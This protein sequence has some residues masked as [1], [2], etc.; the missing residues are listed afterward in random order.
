MRRRLTR[1]LQTSLVAPSGYGAQIFAVMNGPTR[2][3]LNAGLHSFTSVHSSLQ[4]MSLIQ[5]ELPQSS[6]VV[7]GLPIRPLP[8]APARHA[9]SPSL[10]SQRSPCA[11]SRLSSQKVPGPAS[12]YRCTYGASDAAS[13]PPPLSRGSAPASVRTPESSGCTPASGSS[14]GAIPALGVLVEQ[15]R[16]PMS[17]KCAR[18]ATV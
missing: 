18:I 9:Q 6:P 15:A 1:R 10:H 12:P 14:P 8:R 4:S 3:L 11:H 5:I 17:R 16:T 7:Q 13:L 2:H